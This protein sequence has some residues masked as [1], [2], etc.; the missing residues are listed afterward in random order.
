MTQLLDRAFETVRGLPPET[1]DALA[2]IL[3]HLAGDD[4]SALRLG[5]D[6]EAP[7]EASLAQAER[8]DFATDEQIKAIWAKH[9]L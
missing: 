5:A 6:E 3:L 7:F 8:G 2:R 1:Q 4:Q 9:G